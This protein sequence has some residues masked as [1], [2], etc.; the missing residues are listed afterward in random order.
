MLEGPVAVVDGVRD[1][2]SRGRHGRQYASRLV[3]EPSAPALRMGAATRVVPANHQM[4]FRN[5]K[6]HDDS[7]RFVAYCLLTHSQLSPIPAL[8][9]PYLSPISALSQPYLSPISAL[10]Q[11]D[12]SPVPAQSQPNP[13]LIPR[14]SFGQDNNNKRHPPLSNGARHPRSRGVFSVI[15]LLLRCLHA[16]DCKFGFVSYKQSRP[17]LGLAGRSRHITHPRI[18]GLCHWA[19]ETAGHL[20]AESPSR[21]TAGPANV[22]K[23]SPP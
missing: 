23:A 9:Q 6:M 22:R 17:R 20:G 10:S 21:L 2:R 12:L 7:G 19:G 14:L 8:S 16:G 1:E 4:A 3:A 18:W 11:P 15:T 5:T 13:N